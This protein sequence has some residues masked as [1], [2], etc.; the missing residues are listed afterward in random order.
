MNDQIN[1][2][3]RADECP[4]NVKE[5]DSLDAYVTL[6]ESRNHMLPLSMSKA[7]SSHHVKQ[8][9]DKMEA[10]GDHDIGSLGDM[11]KKKMSDDGTDSA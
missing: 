7:S 8:E 4:A 11:I 10:S 2:V 1:G 6:H 9:Y 3:I 5:G